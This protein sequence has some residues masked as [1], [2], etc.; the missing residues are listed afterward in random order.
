MKSVIKTFSLLSDETRLRILN[1]LTGGEACVHEVT[2]AL[3]I[4]QSTASRGLTALYDAG[5]VI[6][7]KEGPWTL[8]AIRWE[9]MSSYKAQIVNVII[10]ELENDQIVAGDKKSMVEA[11]RSSHRAAGAGVSAGVGFLKPGA[12]PL[13]EKPAGGERRA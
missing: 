4:S 10:A 9:G 13:G 11:K 3:G 8:Y 1:V 12:Y 2:K 5:L 7:R 6:M